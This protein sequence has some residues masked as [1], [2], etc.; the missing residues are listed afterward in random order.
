MDNS[1]S[2]DSLPLDSPGQ[3]VKAGFHCHTVNSDGG[4][5]PEE[6]VGYYRD[7]GFRCIGVTD[8]FAVTPIEHLSD[9]GFIAIDSTE[10]G[11]NPDIIGV[12]VSA[13]MP[14][15]GSL[16]QR[17]KGLAE[18]GGFT[19]AAHPTYCAVTPDMYLDCPDRTRRFPG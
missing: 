12:G 4:M 15:E 13:A 3:W 14:E 10:N 6:T 1:F 5:S 11:G 16:A 7:K 17:A 19:I 2:F 8:H 18:Q 9:E